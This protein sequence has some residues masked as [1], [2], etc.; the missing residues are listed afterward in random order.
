MYKEINYLIIENN[1]GGDQHWLP[2]K[3]MQGGGCSTIVA[4]ELCTCLANVSDLYRHISPLSYFPSKDEY[5]SFCVKM[6]NF[7]W[8]KYRGL[9]SLDYFEQSLNDYLKIT[10]TAVHYSKLLDTD[11]YENAKAF[12]KHYINRNLPVAFLLLEHESRLIYDLTW[13]WFNI[14]GYEESP[15]GDFDVIFATFGEKCRLSLFSLWNKGNPIKR[16]QDDEFGG[17]IAID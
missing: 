5:I 16:T 1:Y 3:M 10:D 17:L 15:D 13:H 7:V 8:P 12:I 9:P 4:A 2:E 14:T 11:S 6:F